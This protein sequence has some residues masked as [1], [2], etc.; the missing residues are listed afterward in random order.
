M[1]LVCVLPMQSAHEAAGATG[2]R[3]SPRPHWGERFINGSGALRCEIA[4]ACLKSF[5]LLKIEVG[6]C[7]AILNLTPRNALVMPGLDPGIHQSS[8]RVF[9]RRWITGSSLAMTI[10]IGMT[11]FAGATRRSFAEPVIG[12]AFAQTLRG[13]L[14]PRE[15]G[16]V[17]LEFF[18]DRFGDARAGAQALV[19]GFHRRPF[20]K[21]DRRRR[22]GPVDDCHQISVGDAEMVEQEFAALEI[23]RA[24]CRERV[25][26]SV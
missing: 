6:A 2:I 13:R 17:Q 1:L 15:F 16:L 25:F 23:G 22:H 19:I 5:W 3:H 14:V 7:E 4:K 24:S 26:S 9:R 10:S 8:R 20:F 11:V 12:R 21:F 18:G